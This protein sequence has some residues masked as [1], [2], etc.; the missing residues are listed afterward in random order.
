MRNT[1]SHDGKVDPGPHFFKALRGR[2]NGSGRANHF[3]INGPVL[4][5]ALRGRVIGY[6]CFTVQVEFWGNP[7]NWPEFHIARNQSP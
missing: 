6:G 2:V 7:A 3:L 4:R 1:V 5:K